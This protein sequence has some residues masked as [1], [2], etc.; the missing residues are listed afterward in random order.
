MSD[1]E[2]LNWIYDR[3]A[4]VHGENPSTDYM[5]RLEKIVKEVSDE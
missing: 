2:F 5:L 4:H 3:L 1:H